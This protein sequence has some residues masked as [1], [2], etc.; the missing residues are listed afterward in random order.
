[1]TQSVNDLLIDLV[2]TTRAMLTCG[3]T[4]CGTGS[5]NGS[6]DHD[7][8]TQSVNGLLID[9]V[10]T[11][12]AMLTCGQT[13]CGTG[14]LNGSIDHDV[15]TQSCGLVTGVGI[16]ALAGEGGITGLGTGGSGNHFLVAVRM[17]LLSTVVSFRILGRIKEANKLN[18]KIITFGIITSDEVKAAVIES[19]SVQ[20]G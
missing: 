14:S 3:Q 9:L 2:I 18:V 10:I 4:G 13:G 12:R 15:V 6:I 11:T 17:H 5:L 19:R 7:V 16:A 8:V 20:T 1:M